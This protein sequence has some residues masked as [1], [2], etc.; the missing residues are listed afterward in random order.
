[1]S[2]HSCQAPAI[3]II[4]HIRTVS[5]K[6]S[7]SERSLSFSHTAG[8]CPFWSNNPWLKAHESSRASSIWHVCWPLW[9]TCCSRL[10]LTLAGPLRCQ[11]P[12]SFSCQAGGDWQKKCLPLLQFDSQRRDANLVAESFALFPQGIE[13]G[14]GWASLKREIF[15]LDRICH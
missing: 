1:M 8:I 9:V 3:P 10:V 11:D 7:R 4:Q 15:V 12:S 6:V 2:F 5:S 13:R 14:G